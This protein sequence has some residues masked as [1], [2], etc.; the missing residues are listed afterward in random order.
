VLLSRVFLVRHGQA[1]T[2]K[3]YDALS[4]SGRLQ[5]RL[6]GEYFAAEGIHFATAYSGELARQQQT[7]EEVREAYRE[8]GAAFP[9]V[10]AQ[11]GWN[12]FDLDHVYQTL[13]PMLCAEDAGFQKEYEDMVTQARIAAEQPEAQINR[14]WLPCDKKLVHAWIQGKHPYPGE[15]WQA[16]RARVTACRVMLEEG[17]R[18]QNVVVFTSATP[19]AI[20][21]ALAMEIEDVR[22]MRLAGALHNASCS[23]IRLIDGELRLHSFNEVPH[24]RSPDL[25][26]YR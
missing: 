22:V 3:A 18:D 7:A 19:I 10:V 12:E 11:S 20:W 13:A 16:F 4:D 17:D 8:A 5:A 25:R 23:V 21:I 1:G 9:D 2:R 6:L 15:S 26:T 24:L 14:R